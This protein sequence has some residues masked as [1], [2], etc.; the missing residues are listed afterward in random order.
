GMAS[1]PPPFTGQYGTVTSRLASSGY[2]WTAD[3]T[4][5]PSRSLLNVPFQKA[6][7]ASMLLQAVRMARWALSGEFF[8]KSSSHFF[9]LGPLLLASDSIF[10]SILETKMARSL[11]F[12]VPPLK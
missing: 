1:T 6:I 5:W 12:A 9:P 7:R 11:V 10:P 8:N 2:A 4:L 3:L